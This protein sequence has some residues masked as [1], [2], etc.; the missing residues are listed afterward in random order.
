MKEK[1]IKESKK[2]KKLFKEEWYSSLT[3]E[4]KLSILGALAEELKPYINKQ[5]NED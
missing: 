3:E 4:Q 1:K 2:R 5:N